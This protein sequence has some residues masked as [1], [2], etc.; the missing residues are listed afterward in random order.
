[1]CNHELRKNQRPK[2]IQTQILFHDHG[3]ICIYS[4]NYGTNCVI[5]IPIILLMILI[6][7]ENN[8]LKQGEGK[9]SATVRLMNST[10]GTNINSTG[11]TIGIFLVL[12]TKIKNTYT[13]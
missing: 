8:Q 4:C 6:M 3:H 9:K 13:I 1:M 2:H 5:I 11:V 10:S 7:N 12:I